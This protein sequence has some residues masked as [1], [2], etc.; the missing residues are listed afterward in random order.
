MT[1]RGFTVVYPGPARLTLVALFAV[2]AAM[3]YPWHTDTQRWILGVAV[4]VALLTLSW[5]R[6]AH[7]STQ[8]WRRL[9]MLVPRRGGH[10]VH[11]GLDRGA[12][13]A[14]TTAVLS[15]RGGPEATELPLALIAGYR[16]RYG[17]RADG[18]RIVQCETADGTSIFIGLTIAAAPNLAALQARSS[19]IPLWDTAEAAARRLADQLRELG[20][21]AVPAV[22]IEVPELLGPEAKARWR[23]V[24]DGAAGYVTGYALQADSGLPEAIDELWAADC[25]ERWTVAEIRGDGVAVAAAVRTDD[26]PESDGSGPIAVRG[27]QAAA[28]AALHPMSVRPVLAACGPIE[29]LDELSWPVAEALKA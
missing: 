9:A 5:W 20:F 17:V 4:A 3:A 13:D 15:V 27:R 14:R 2:P 10:G 16:D 29:L 22:E 18:V 7:L 19:A 11:A 24:S 23:T 1:N 21:D 6:G 8:A 26:A 12:T 28:L 25:T